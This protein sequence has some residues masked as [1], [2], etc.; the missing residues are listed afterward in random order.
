M[1]FCHLDE[2][3]L[4][5]SRS[6]CPLLQNH[7]VFSDH[8]KHPARVSQKLPALT[9]CFQSCYWPSSGGSAPGM[10]ALNVLDLDKEHVLVSTTISHS[11]ALI[12]PSAPGPQVAG[13][14]H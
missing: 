12:S 7:W 11:T 6:L 8:Q 13:Q 9:E 1:H 2:L 3:S 14:G 10:S 5:T 4:L